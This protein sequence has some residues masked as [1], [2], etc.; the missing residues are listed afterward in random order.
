MISM[1]IVL[2]NLCEIFR[3][4]TDAIDTYPRY[5]A[6]YGICLGAAPG[7]AQGP[8]LG[9]KRVYP[10]YVELPA[11]CQ[12][13]CIATLL[14]QLLLRQHVLQELMH[15]GQAHDAH[16]YALRGGELRHLGSTEW[17]G[18]RIV[19]MVNEGVAGGCS[20]RPLQFQQRPKHVTIANVES[21]VLKAARCPAEGQSAKTPLEA[22]CVSARTARHQERVRGQRDG[23]AGAT[24]PIGL[25]VG[26]VYDPHP[27]RLPA[28][29]PN[30][31][32]GSRNRSCIPF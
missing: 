8:N 2:K 24:G 30:R 32:R 26:A 25:E 21:V 20:A 11:S 16:V 5:D 6:I 13:L 4:L 1:F 3:N 19:E 31:L 14:E 28:L 9:L 10:S 29:M 7:Y 15:V 23:G 12:Q 17:G 18:S 27:V 22:L